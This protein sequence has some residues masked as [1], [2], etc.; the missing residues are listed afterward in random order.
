MPAQDDGPSLGCASPLF[1]ISLQRTGGELH[2]H[3]LSEGTPSSSK[4]LGRLLAAGPRGT[5]GSSQLHHFRGRQRLLLEDEDWK[6]RKANSSGPH[7]RYPEDYTLI[8]NNVEHVAS[9]VG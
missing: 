5:V 1:R 4:P 7:S 6:A 3:S 2:L 8:N 9:T